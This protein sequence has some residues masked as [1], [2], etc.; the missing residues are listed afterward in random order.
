MAKKQ[1]FVLIYD[2]EVAGHLAA[3]EPKYHSLIRGAIEEQLRFEPETA[4]RNRKPLQRPIDLGAQVGT[5]VGSGQPLS[6]LLSGGRRMAG[7][8]SGHCRERRQ[9]AVC[10][11]ERGGAMKIASVAEVKARLSSFLNATAEGPVVVTRNGKAV[12]V[13]LGVED[14]EELEG[15]LLAHSR[16]LRPSSTRPTA[17]SMQAPES[18]TTISGDRSSQRIVLVKR[19]GAG[20]SAEPSAAPDR[21]RR[22]R[23]ARR[24]ESLVPTLRAGTK[25][26]ISGSQFP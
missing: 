2:P 24:A 20:R 8:H 23:F 13:L 19:T 3:I 4:T 7:S 10:G 12:A 11:R 25:T 21:R 5:S 9:S 14:D 18:V 17:A 6:R 1:P 16:K 15:L 26:L 22:S